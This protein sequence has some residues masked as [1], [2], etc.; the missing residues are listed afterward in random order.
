MWLLLFL[1]CGGKEPPAAGGSDPV[2]P[3]VPP[4]PAPEEAC[5]LSSCLPEG[6]AELPMGTPLARF[7]EAH[8]EAVAE[9]NSFDFRQ[10]YAL[11]VQGQPYPSVVLYFDSDLPDQPLYE[12]IVNYPEGSDGAA[13]AAELLGPPNDGVEW[14]LALEGEDVPL[15]AWAFEHKVVFAVPWYGTEWN[16]AADAE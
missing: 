6:L 10:V 3:A 16:P 9:D 8:P 2:D 11:S 15:K 1:A 5:S 12:I 4:E 14:S 7:V 13:I